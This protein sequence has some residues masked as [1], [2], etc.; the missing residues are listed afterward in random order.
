MD[1]FKNI[2]ISYKDTWRTFVFKYAKTSST[3]KTG[4]E[5]E[6]RKWTNQERFISVIGMFDSC[7][8]FSNV[9]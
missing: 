8:Y 4:G 5:K 6:G 3:T 7:H 9:I 2:F 1:R